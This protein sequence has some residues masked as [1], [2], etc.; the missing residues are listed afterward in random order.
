MSF[1]RLVYERNIGRNLNNLWSEKGK[2]HTTD[3]SL[4]SGEGSF[5]S[6]DVIG[7]DC[8]GCDD[9]EERLDD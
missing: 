8:S 7:N 5:G 4:G 3:S 6:C 1:S 9:T 2:R